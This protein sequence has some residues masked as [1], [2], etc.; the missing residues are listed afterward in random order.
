MNVGDYAAPGASCA[1]I[2][3]LN[4]MLITAD[5][6]EAEVENLSPGDAVS[7]ATSTGL[8]IE[9]ILTFIGKQSDPV[10]R[11]YPVEI[12]VDNSDYVLRSGLTSTVR[13]SLDE[14]YAHLVSPVL[15]WPA[16]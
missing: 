14:V 10:T 3:D 8:K 15:V 9:G 2:I 7:G 5:V 13:I 12:T 6:T 16:R 11:T 1:T 4:P